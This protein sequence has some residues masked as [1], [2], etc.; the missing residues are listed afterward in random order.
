MGHSVWQSHMAFS[1]G[2]HPISIAIWMRLSGCQTTLFEYD[3]D[4]MGRLWGLQPSPKPTNQGGYG[5]GSKTNNSVA[6]QIERKLLWALQSTTCCYQIKQCTNILS[7]LFVYTVYIYTYI[8]IYIYTD[9]CL[10]CYGDTLHCTFISASNAHGYC[11]CGD[12]GELSSIHQW[13]NKDLYTFSKDC[14]FQWD[15]QDPKIEVLYHIRP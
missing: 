4:F 5:N 1:K 7:F 8:H 14:H 10:T 12:I 9:M 13:T 3:W 15:F 2:I 11:T 6:V